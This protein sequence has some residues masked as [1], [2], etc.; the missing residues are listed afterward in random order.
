MNKIKQNLAWIYF[1]FGDKLEKII[2]NYPF[3]DNF[4][5]PYQIFFKWSFLLDKNKEIWKKVKKK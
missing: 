1:F 2:S 3:M 4:F 5:H